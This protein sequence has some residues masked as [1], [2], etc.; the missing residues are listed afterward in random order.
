MSKLFGKEIKPLT[1]AC[2]LAAV[3]DIR[4]YFNKPRANLYVMVNNVCQANCR[5]CTQHGDYRKFDF[6]KFQKVI[7]ELRRTTD[8]N[9]LCLSKINFTGGEP[10]LYFEKFEKLYNIIFEKFSFNELGNGNVVINTNGIGLKTLTERN[11]IMKNIGFVSVSRHHYD[12]KLNEE[13]FQTNPFPT[14]EDIKNF[15][16]KNQGKLWLRCNCIKGYI[17]STD[18][19]IKYTDWAIDVGCKHCGFTSLMELND[20]CKENYV[21]VDIPTIETLSLVTSSFRYDDNDKLCCNCNRSYYLNDKDDWCDLVTWNRNLE[22]DSPKDGILVFDG[23]YLR[24]GFFGE[25]IC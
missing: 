13:I 1:R 25:V 23:E 2:N 24:Y 16:L 10:L 11:D 12:D 9:E 4:Y 15:S 18:E 8:E 21:Y 20:Y 22:A 17:D 7:D 19:V 5:F 14:T 6:D 3:P